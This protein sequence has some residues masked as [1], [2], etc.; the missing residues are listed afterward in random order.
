MGMMGIDID[1]IG[2][3]SF[4][5]GEAYLRNGLIPLAH[6]PMLILQRRLPQRADA[7]GVVEVEGLRHRPAA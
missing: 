2:N 6:F 5:R 3:H 4:D 7:D 1:A